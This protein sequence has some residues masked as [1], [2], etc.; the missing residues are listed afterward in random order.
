MA[1]EDVRPAPYRPR[2]VDAQIDR[3]LRLF[4]AVEV[5]GARWSG[6]TW[7]ARAHGRSITYVDRGSNLQIVRADPQFAL[8]G[9]NPHV[10]DEWQR[11]PELWDVVRHAVD[12]ADGKR[13]MWIL[14]GSSTP[15]KNQTEHSGVGRIGSVHMRPMSLLESGESTGKVSLASLFEGKFQPCEAPT[16]IA[17]IAESCCR[18]GWPASL[19]FPAE[20]SLEVTREYL[21]ATYEQSIPRMGGEPRTAEQLVQS[22]S[23]NLGQSAKLRTIAADIYAG[24]QAEDGAYIPSEQELRAISRHL[25]MLTSLYLVDEVPGWVPATRSPKRMRTTPKRYFADPSIPVAAL[26]LSPASL[27]QDWQ[28]FGLAFENLCMRD[29]DVYARALPLAGRHPLW[30]YRDDSDLEVDAVIELTDGRWGAFEIKMGEDEVADGTRNLLRMRNKLLKNP[31]ARMREPSFLA[32]IL[33]N[34]ESARRNPDGV[35]VI[36]IRTLGV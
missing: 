1:T 33:A 29:L 10:I 35:Y 14:T 3:Y 36:P 20:D 4:G 30:Y 16:G 22:I 34:A 32:V 21:Q 15:T 17:Q 28:T 27:M 8:Q 24:L 26:G 13:G 11:V 6:K 12:D 9:E 7:S 2:V 23:R 31:K 25:D 19:D 18:G 5:T